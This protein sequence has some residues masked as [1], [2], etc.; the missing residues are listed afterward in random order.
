M[1]LPSMVVKSYFKIKVYTLDMFKKISP[2]IFS[3]HSTVGTPDQLTMMRARGFFTTS[4]PPGQ[5]SSLT[6][7]LSW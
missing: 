4:N 2:Y 7:A 5:R 6:H 3:I 1:I